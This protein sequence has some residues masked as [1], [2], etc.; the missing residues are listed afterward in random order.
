VSQHAGGGQG[1]PVDNRAQN[2]KIYSEEQYVRELDGNHGR[3]PSAVARLGK[4]GEYNTV[5]HKNTHESKLKIRGQG[6]I[7]FSKG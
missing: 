5:D 6:G 1:H 7:G 3:R 4:D 2:V